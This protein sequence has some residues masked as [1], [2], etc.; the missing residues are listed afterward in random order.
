M[1]NIKTISLA[2]VAT[3]FVTTIAIVACS[4]ESTG[5][6]E[7]NTKQD[8]P[9]PKCASVA[10][11]LASTLYSFWKNSDQAYN[12]NPELFLQTCEN[13]DYSS[14]F[15][16]TG[17]PSSQ[18]DYIDS[19]ARIEYSNINTTDEMNTDEC[20]PCLSGGLY[21]YGQAVKDLHIILQGMKDLGYDDTIPVRE[22]NMDFCVS[23]CYRLYTIFPSELVQC[24]LDC[25]IKR[26]MAEAD[27]N[28]WI[29]QP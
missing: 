14:F 25:E 23:E 12:S 29:I 13:E 19:L 4:K 26:R 18:M 2:I 24:L 27:S 20:I 28:Y 9:A 11:E 5:R 22:F 8:P 6:T 17:I 10:N 15:Q 3:L 21:Q 7:Q 16:I 1:K